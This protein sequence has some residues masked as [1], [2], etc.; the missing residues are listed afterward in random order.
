MKLLLFDIDGTLLRSH[1]AGRRLFESILAE[2]CDRPISTTDVSFSGR[3][4]PLIIQETLEKAG[5]APESIARLLPIAL[6]QYANLASYTPDDIQI[7]PGV[8][9]LLKQLEVRRDVQLGLLTGNLERTAYLK[10]GC[11]DLSHFFPF[12]AFGSDHAVRSRLPAIAAARAKRFNGH[13]YSGRDVVIIGDSVRDVQCG[14]DN[15][16]FT[17][18]VATGL[19]SR[20]TLAAED[21]DVLLDDL[22]DSQQFCQCVLSPNQASANT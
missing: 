17:V 14:K 1:G 12:G 16:A 21:P 2:L 22:A 4:D 20:A 5:F 7:L 3:T 19:T 18:A 13:T 10:V 6:E 11:V 15:D 9:T 8:R